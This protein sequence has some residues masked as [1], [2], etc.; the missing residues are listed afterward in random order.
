MAGNA[1]FLASGKSKKPM[2]A[3]SSRRCL[4]DLFLMWNPLFGYL[5]K[6]GRPDSVIPKALPISIF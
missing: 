5:K 2:Q 1:L 3:R 4:A 6:F